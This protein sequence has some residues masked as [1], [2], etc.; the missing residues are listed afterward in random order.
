MMTIVVNAEEKFD[1]T[2]TK[3]SRTSRPSRTPS[4][5]SHNAQATPR[6]SGGAPP[7]RRC[8]TAVTP[9]GWTAAAPGTPAILDTRKC[10]TCPAK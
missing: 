1:V 2:I 6:A 4:T 10:R 9:G 5:S 7:C 3:R 8:A